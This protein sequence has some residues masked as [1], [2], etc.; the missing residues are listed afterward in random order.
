MEIELD[1]EN[2]ILYGKSLI[3][4][5]NNSPDD[6]EYL[7]VQLDQNIRKKNSPALDKNPSAMSIMCEP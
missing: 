5:Q 2:D 4:Y 3:T 1:E 6:L 7:W